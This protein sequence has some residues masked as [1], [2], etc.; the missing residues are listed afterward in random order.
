ML[1]LPAETWVRFGIWMVVGL[2]VYFA[3]ARR[4]SRVA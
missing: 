3:Y 4:H 1:N 2:V